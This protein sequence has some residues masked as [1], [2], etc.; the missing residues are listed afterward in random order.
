MLDLNLDA[1]TNILILKD[2]KTVLST[3]FPCLQALGP[4]S[5]SKTALLGLTR[6]L[7]PELA[8]SNIRVNCVAPGVIKTRFSSAVRL[9]FSDILFVFDLTRFHFTWVPFFLCLF[10]QLWENEDIVDDFKSQLCIKRYSLYYTML[11]AHVCVWLK[12]KI[13][14]LLR[15]SLQ[16][17]RARG[18]W[19]SD[20]LLVLWGG[21][22][23]H[24]RDHHSD[25][26]DGLSTL[27]IWIS[28]N[29]HT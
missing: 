8:H 17:R 24:G 15:F 14:I 19:W 22:L 16:N 23:H 9:L 27:K 29:L 1:S 26:R 21:V 6:A 11:C 18:N 10:T 20:C 2:I 13:H 12:I 4:Y 7:A 28:D 25:R 3:D 5:V